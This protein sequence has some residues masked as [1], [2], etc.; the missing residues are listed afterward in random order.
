MQGGFCELLDSNFQNNQTLCLIKEH[1]FQVPAHS[2]SHTTSLTWKPPLT[3]TLH[4]FQTSTALALLQFYTQAATVPSHCNCSQINVDTKRKQAMPD[5]LYS[6]PCQSC[7]PGPLSTWC[8]STGGWWCS[9]DSMHTSYE[10]QMLWKAKHFCAA[11][12][13]LSNL[14]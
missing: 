9:W 5:S 13:D 12:V 10:L 14:L 11:T 4:C 7:C 2:A 3:Q 1:C 6:G 8:C